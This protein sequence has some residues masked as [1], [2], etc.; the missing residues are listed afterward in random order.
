MTILA[1]R[2]RLVRTMGSF[3]AA[4][5]MLA[6]AGCKDLDVGNL[7]GASAEGLATA[8]TAQQLIA[9]SQQLVNSW[10]S[11]DN[12]HA[13]TLSKYGYERWSFR[14][15]EPRGLTDVVTSPITG[16]FWSYGTVKNIR[17]LLDALPTIP[18]TAMSDAEKAG[19]RGWLKLNLAIQYEDMIQAHDQFGIV[20]DLPADPLTEVPVIAS[21]TA[22]WDRVFTLIDEANTE[23]ATTG[24]VFPMKMSTGFTGY[25]T[26]ATMVKLNR[27]LKARW[28]VTYA[29]PGAAGA[30][31]WA[32]ARVALDSSFLA[33]P[34][35]TATAAQLR[36]GPYHTYD[37][38]SGNTNGLSNAD[39]YSNERVKLEAQC[40]ALPVSGT[41]SADT[42]QAN[43][44]GRAYGAT[45]RLRLL[46]TNQFATLLTVTAKYRL[47]DFL[48]PV[49]SANISSTASLPVIRNE[50][51]IL[52][53]A[54]IKYNQGD[55]SGAIASIN[56][57]RTS[58]IANLPPI[59]DPYVPVAALNQPSTLLGE[60]LYEKRFSLWGET[61][62]V[63]VD[64]RHYGVADKIPHFDPSFRIFDVFPIPT[65]ECDVRGYTVTGCF[66][67]GYAGI[68]GGTELLSQSLNSIPE[69]VP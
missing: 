19:L 53:D 59:S 39:S 11:T 43:R 34:A 68:Q 23:L 61:G 14:S 30:A 67:G 63:W 26:P 2:N 65:S 27:A 38:T 62:T 29:A 36:T 12:S 37:G 41:C 8:P 46:N 21:R 42:T 22:A 66:Q 56:K 57:V 31:T 54:E 58:A 47:T 17:V 1:K 10:R 20:L 32:K 64:M 69:V 60:L 40:K 33:I 24:A 51:L 18:S 3:A 44:D 4:A 6:M 52:L 5:A 45:A 50:E 9:A 35:G 15:S 48:A 55:K 25:N 16:G 49:A 28:L 13:S 7:N